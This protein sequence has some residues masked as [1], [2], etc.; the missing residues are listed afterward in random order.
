[1]ANAPASNEGYASNPYNP[2]A[3]NSP[4][5]GNGA[6]NPY[7]SNTA[8]NP[9]YT[10]PPLESYL[11]GVP[12]QTTPPASTSAVILAK[13]ANAT[14]IQKRVAL[15]VLSLVFVASVFG[16]F[17]G[18]NDYQTT[19]TLKQGIAQDQQGKFDEAG[20]TLTKASKGIAYP[21]T[22][23]AVK[24]AIANNK[25]WKEYYTWHKQA[26]DLVNNKQ[27]AAAL[28]LLY[29][30]NNDY[31]LYGDI[32]SLITIA[33]AGGDTSTIASMSVDQTPAVDGASATIDTSTSN[34]GNYSIPY[35]PSS[36]GGGGYVSPP[37][38]TVKPTVVPPPINPTP[39]PYVPP[40]APPIK[41]V[42]KGDGVT[43]LGTYVSGSGCVGVTYN[44][45]GG[46]VTLTSANCQ[47]EPV[48]E[49]GGLG[50]ATSNCTGT[51]YYNGGSMHVVGN[52]QIWGSAGGHTSYTIRSYIGNDNMACVSISAQ[53]ANGYPHQYIRPWVNPATILCGGAA[54]CSVK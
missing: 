10:P 15:A 54:P 37:K 25:R 29:K 17:F 35:I 2:Q 42:Y 12:G 32:S 39:T 33:L 44:S 4:Y 27:Y 47:T 45:G 30:I 9:N 53:S 6:Y 41:Y 21:G 7:A 52:S 40:P 48:T 49:H 24:Q 20:D 23:K 3:N 22:K 38:P 19:K 1:M 36:G 43:R 28:E 14:P 11:E 5:A 16:G 31:P 51:A 8:Y 13:L 18:Y 46:N 50:F 34:S 26:E